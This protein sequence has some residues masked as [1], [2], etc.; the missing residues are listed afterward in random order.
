MRKSLCLMG[1][2]GVIAAALLVAATLR[3]QGQLSKLVQDFVKVSAPVVALEHVRVIDG[4]GAAPAEDQ[5]VVIENGRIRAV[6]SAGS[7]TPPPGAQALDLSGYTVIPGPVGMHDHLF[8][9]SQFAERASAGRVVLY[10]EMGFSFPRLYLAGGVTSL[11]TTGSVEPYTDLSLKKLIDQG[12]TPGPKIHVTGPYLEGPGAYTPNMHE[13]ADAEDAARTVNY[14]AAEGATSFKAYMHITRAEL[15]AAIEAAH[16]RG[17]KVTGHLCSIGFMEAAALGIDDLEHGLFVDTEF[18]Q[19][20]QP[21]VCPSQ[22]LTAATMA[23]LDVESAPVQGMIRDLVSHH[24]AVTSTLPVFEIS[25]P[26]RPPLQTRVLD[27]LSGPSRIDYLTTRALVGQREHSNAST[28]LGKEMQFERDFVKAGGLLLAGLDPTGYGGVVAGFGDQ[29]EVELLVQAGFSPTE[30]IH[31]ATENGAQFLGE[32]DK[33]G[34]VAP[35]KLADLVVVHGNPA[36]NIEDI[37]KVGIVFKDG[38]GYDSAK[39][40]ESVRGAVGLR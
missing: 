30:A 38:V 18:D 23:D 1:P 21:D 19:G 11:R 17:I 5:T 31:I 26:D 4:T 22:Q 16:G 7:T 20:K 8:Y 15:K 3:A 40:I 29:R 12:E 32:A 37:E 39:L 2:I 14:W 33:I 27:V 10:N 9:P 28:N 25:V 36:A 35:G 6:G 34:T 13:L 24:V